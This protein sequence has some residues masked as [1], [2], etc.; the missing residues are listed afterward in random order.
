MSTLGL[1][2]ALAALWILLAAWLAG[3]GALLL[4]DDPAEGAC[5]SLHLAF[6]MGAA[7][8]TALLMVWHLALAVD[9]W[10]AGAVAALGVAGWVTRRTWFRACSRG[11]PAIVAILGAAALAVWVAN[12]ALNAGG[13][14][15]YNYE[16]QAIRWIH[17]FPIVPGLANLHGRLGFNQAHHL[18]AALWSV[19]PLGGVVNH[20]LNGLFVTVSLLY[21][22][23]GLHAV[24][25]GH[26]DP[27]PSEVVR[28]VCLG[29]TLG[30]VL[31]GVF[32]PAISTLKADVLVTCCVLLITCLAFE[33][34]EQPA[35]SPRQLR[36]AACAI[37]AAGFAA[38]VKLSAGVFCGVM[39]LALAHKV[40]RTARGWRARRPVVA[41]IGV[42]AVMTLALPLRGILLSGYPLYPATVGAVDV[43][44]RVPGAQAVAERTFITSIAQLRP[45]YDPRAVSGFGWVRNWVRETAITDRFSLLLP[46][47]VAVFVIAGAALPGRADGFVPANGARWTCT[48]VASSSLASLV[49][50]WHQ[51]PASRFGA[52]Y[53]WA[54][55]ASCLVA[56]RARGRAT[57]P[58]AVIIAAGLMLGAVIA[59]GGPRADLALA[60]TEVVALGALVALAAVTDGSRRLTAAA[61]A[62]LLL[63]PVGERVSAHVARGRLSDA[64]AVAWLTPDRYPDRSARF[65]D[66]P[67]VT[68]SG[69]VVYETRSARFETALPNTRY[70]NPLLE[71]RTP[72]LLSGGFR[73]GAASRSS[74]YGYSVE[75]V[76]SPDPQD[77]ERVSSAVER[78]MR[79]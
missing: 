47:T 4:G 66:V 64:L 16:F 59:A 28:A 70:F 45:T 48:V 19:G 32:G 11:R 1:S 13:M 25:M 57:S 55:A 53:A 77:Q 23:G 7:A 26:D 51:A 42:V 30:L 44:W 67:R 24:V 65:A 9:A 74:E 14:D 31:F 72:G 75:F 71:A 49:V 6:W 21:Q 40:W 34:G 33:V 3:I 36:L 54:L 73:V 2:L 29:P 76:S 37:A 69:L 10:A 79:R 20:V 12:H 39:A 22:G 27:R 15:D 8:T 52:G 68:L 50:W 58:A 62:M 46:L 63:A 18:L 60:A 35:G 17:D 41:A 56:A 61:L 78:V 38:S 5:E 43:D